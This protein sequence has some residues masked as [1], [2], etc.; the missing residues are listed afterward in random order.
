MSGATDLSQRKQAV[1]VFGVFW[2]TNRKCV[3]SCSEST[4]EVLLRVLEILCVSVWKHELHFWRD[5]R[6]RVTRGWIPGVR[7]PELSLEEGKN[8]P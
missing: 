8:Q 7:P 1:C 6:E 2:E 4:H 3:V 5:R